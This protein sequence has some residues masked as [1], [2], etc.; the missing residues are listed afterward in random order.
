M[1]LQWAA[2]GS[3]GSERHKKILLQ[4]SIDLDELNAAVPLVSIFSHAVKKVVAA[5]RVSHPYFGKNRFRHDVP[6]RL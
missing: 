3:E 6:Y 2:S 4:K 5:L 1:C